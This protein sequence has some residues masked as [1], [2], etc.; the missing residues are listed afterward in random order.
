MTLRP[1][2]IGNRRGR[3]H[4]PGP[5]QG[6]TRSARNCAS[7]ATVALRMATSRGRRVHGRRRRPNG[8]RLVYLV[9][10]PTDVELA[11]GACARLSVVVGTDAHAPLA[12]EAI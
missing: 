3:S 10:G 4:A 9:D 6:S 1:A 2:N 5:R 11:A 12:I 8:Q 7:P